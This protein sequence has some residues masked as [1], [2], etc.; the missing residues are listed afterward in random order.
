MKQFN[1]VN[2]DVGVTKAEVRLYCY[3]PIEGRSE[4]VFSDTINQKD[5]KHSTKG[6]M[7]DVCDDIFRE[8]TRHCGQ[9]WPLGRWSK[10]RGYDWHY[11][12]TSVE[13][14]KLLTEL[15]SLYYGKPS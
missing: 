9:I 3:E 12:S 5:G 2:V 1:L 6:E 4:L 15:S 10:Q 11:L 13:E 7:I 14:R 8:L